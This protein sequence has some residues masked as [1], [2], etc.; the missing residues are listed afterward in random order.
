LSK[1]TI[2]RLKRLGTKDETY[3]DIINRLIK[4]QERLSNAK[5]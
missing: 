1:S 2:E 5:N 3:D 4:T